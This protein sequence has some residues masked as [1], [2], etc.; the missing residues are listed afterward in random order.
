VALL[1]YSW[2]VFA[3]LNIEH[4]DIGLAKALGLQTYDSQRLWRKLGLEI[5]LMVVAATQWRVFERQRQER[6][7][8]LGIDADDT[9]AEE[10]ME[11]TRQREES[12]ASFTSTS[13]SASQLQRQSS[14]E[15][16]AAAQKRTRMLSMT[17]NVPATNIDLIFDN[18]SVSCKNAN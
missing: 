5:V 12:T 16:Q 3:P 11:S 1:L 14:V 7:A 9:S 15:S 2:S 4:I 17:S 13:T 8:V 18:R 6:E 10:I